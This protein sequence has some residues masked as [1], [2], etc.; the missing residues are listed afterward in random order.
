[1]KKKIKI[2]LLVFILAIILTGCKSNNNPII[3]YG[4]EG[5]KNFFDIILVMPISYL[6]NFIAQLFNGNLG[7]GI[8]FTT[9]IVRTLAWPIYAKTNSF[10]RKMQEMQPDLD[11]L[12]A[13]YLTKTDPA[14]QQKKQMEMMAIYKKHKFSPLGCLTPFLQMPIFYAMY[15]TVN[16]ITKEGGKFASNLHSKFLGI[17]LAVHSEGINF[18]DWI[19]II[20]GI[21]VGGTMF[22]LQFYSQRYAKKKQPNRPRVQTTEQATTEKTMKFMNYF[23]IIMMA[24]VAFTSRPLALY[25]IIGNLYSLAQNVF[26]NYLN[27]RHSKKKEPEIR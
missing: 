17:D 20:M 14:S 23:M 10:S 21:L 2:L 4:D 6:L 7:V 11:R 22:L 16:R 24:L 12:N 9:L 5:D 27:D 13:K 25:W 1:M 18:K 26:Q 19:G 15:E 8:I 3:G